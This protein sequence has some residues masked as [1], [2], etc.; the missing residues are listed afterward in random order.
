MRKIVRDMCKPS[1]ARLEA[2]DQRQRLLNRLVHRM[3][4]VAK[5][6]KDEYIEILQEGNRRLWHCTEI[7]KVGRVAKTKT[8][9][10][11][12]AV[13]ERYRG[14]CSFEQVNRSVDEI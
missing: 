9:N 3:R 5:R 7:G 1:A 12:V 4:R 14:D 2:V 13:N 10:R 8:E 6:I 11:D